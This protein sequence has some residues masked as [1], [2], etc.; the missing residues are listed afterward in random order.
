MARYE[1]HFVVVAVVEDG[2]AS[3]IVDDETCQAR[4]PEGAIRDSYKNEWLSGRGT[5][6]GQVDWE[7]NVQLCERLEVK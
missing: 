7:V 6:L 5:E 3:F 4:F 1:H 2:V